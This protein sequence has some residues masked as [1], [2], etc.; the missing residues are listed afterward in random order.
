MQKIIVNEDVNERIDKYLSD[1][2]D[3]SRSLILKMLKDECI[4]VNDNI[5]KAS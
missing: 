3:Y 5:V 1:I 2:T 4:L